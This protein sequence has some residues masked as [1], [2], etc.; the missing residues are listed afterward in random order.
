METTAHAKHSTLD[1]PP[2]KRHRTDAPTQEISEQ[3]MNT[4][5]QGN[6]IDD[7]N[8]IL[9]P[10][11]THVLVRAEDWAAAY[12]DATPYP[13]GVIRDF[14]KHGFL[15]ECGYFCISFVPLCRSPK[16]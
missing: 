6:N 12:R 10:I 8:K 2:T 11:A 4:N 14:C 1:P 15:G 9:D 16:N 3:S 13:H 7:Q 5:G